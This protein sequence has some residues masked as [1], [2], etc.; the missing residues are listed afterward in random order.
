MAVF[1]LDAF[2]VQLIV[3]IIVIAPAIW[4]AGRLLVGKEKAKGT[5]AIW[6]VVLGVVI[7]DI[8]HYFFGQGV[9]ASIILLIILLGLVK[10]FF[11]TGWLKALA[12]AIVAVILFIV[13][14]IIVAVV[15]GLVLTAF[16][17]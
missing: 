10:H 2:V 14:A 11:D 17:I 7:S 15:F 9:I 5:D 6:I 4:I 13:V 3:S 16:F 8:F 1:N 12:I